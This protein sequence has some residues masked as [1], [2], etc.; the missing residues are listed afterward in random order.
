MKMTDS[1]GMASLS[2]MARP[3]FPCRLLSH[4]GKNNPRG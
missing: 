4:D 1:S 2:E 3:L